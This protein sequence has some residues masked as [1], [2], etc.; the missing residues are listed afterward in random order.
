MNLGT[1]LALLCIALI[2]Y[3]TASLLI[4]TKGFLLARTMIHKN[5][6]CEE[7]F[8]SKT[9]DLSHGGHRGCWT[10]SRYKKA[11]VIVID[12]LKFDFMLFN[13]SLKFNVPHFK[14][15]LK[16]IDNIL[17]RHPQNSRLYK[18]MA[19]PPTTTLQRLKG[20]TTGSLPTF[21]DAGANFDSSEITE[22][23]F[24]DQFIKNNKD[25]TFF[26]DDTWQSLYPGRF[27]VSHAFPS[28]N[29]KDLHTVDNGILKHIFHEMRKTDWDLI[30]AH[31]LGVDHCGHRFGPEHPAMAEK[32]IQMD[33]MIK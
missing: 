11:I 4:F 33:Q 28:F 7:D 27:S 20:L 21:V 12:A 1:K 14:N 18:F 17:H 30:I 31:F 26:G 22:D 6:S 19:D 29:V 24:I 3:Y 13:S 15:K 10:H 32:L 9:D 25:I 5:N 8:V 2:I 16:T 23:N